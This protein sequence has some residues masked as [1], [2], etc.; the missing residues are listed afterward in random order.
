MRMFIQKRNSKGKYDYIKGGFSHMSRNLDMEVELEIGEYQIFAYV[1]WRHHIYDINLTF[2]GN[3]KIIFEKVST[4]KDHNIITEGLESY[5]L[6]YGKRSALG[7]CHQYVIYHQETNQILTTIVNT[8][9]KEYKFVQDYK[10]M[11]FQTLHL[12]N[13]TNNL[14]NSLEGLNKEQL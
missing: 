11:N 12:M 1:S 13:L 3:A 8:S 9:L 7:H 2:Y 10:K 4:L 5:N 14:H 6:E